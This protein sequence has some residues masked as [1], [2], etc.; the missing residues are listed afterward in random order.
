MSLLK[1]TYPHPLLPR[2]AP[3]FLLTSTAWK[4]PSQHTWGAHPLLSSRGMLCLCLLTRTLPLKQSVGCAWLPYQG[5]HSET[6]ESSF[7]FLP[8]IQPSFFWPSLSHDSEIASG[9]AFRNSMHC[10]EFTTVDKFTQLRRRQAPCL[11]I[12]RQVWPG[13]LSSCSSWLGWWMDP[14]PQTLW[15]RKGRQPYSLFHIYFPKFPG[16]LW[17]NGYNK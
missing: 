14:N 4:P 6:E 11:K 9:A 3:A 8:P 5:C 12:P 15:S 1:Q 2:F 7:C 10:S 13:G 16:V 17:Q